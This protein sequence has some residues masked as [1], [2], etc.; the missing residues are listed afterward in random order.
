ML[1]R[2][3][4]YIAIWMEEYMVSMSLMIRS[5]FPRLLSIQTQDLSAIG[6]QG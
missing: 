2:S 5:L 6:E 3:E 4:H 1:S